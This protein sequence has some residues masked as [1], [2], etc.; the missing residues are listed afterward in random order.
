MNKKLKHHQSVIPGNGLAV[1]V[2]NQDIAFAL[3]TWKRKLKDNNI[4]DELKSRQEF[5]KPSV[6]KRDEISRAAFK[7]RKQ[8]ERI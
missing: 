6:I 8:S 7:Q 3:K 5:V 4:L 1:N 2:V